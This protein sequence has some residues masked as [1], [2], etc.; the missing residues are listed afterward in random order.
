MCYYEIYRGIQLDR[1][2]IVDEVRSEFVVLGEHMGKT[3]EPPMRLHGLVGIY[4]CVAW[5]SVS[6]FCEPLSLSL[7]SAFVSPLSLCNCAGFGAIRHFV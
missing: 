6:S 3:S 1:T 2:S 4:T 7:S 5:F